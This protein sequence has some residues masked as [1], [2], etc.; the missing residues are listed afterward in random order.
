MSETFTEAQRAALED[1]AFLL[2][3]AEFAGTPAH[4]AAC[5]AALA[6]LTRLAEENVRLEA[7][8]QEFSLDARLLSVRAANAT[9]TPEKLHALLAAARHEGSS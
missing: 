3:L 6:E 8:L 7:A 9:M 5:T 2:T 4:V 1:V